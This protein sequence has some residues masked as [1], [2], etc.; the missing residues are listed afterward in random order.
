MSKS[1]PH[2]TG[3]PR[4]F[5]RRSFLKAAGASA[6]LLPFLPTLERHAE[7]A[8]GASKRMIVITH[9]NGNILT[10]WRPTGGEEDF[11]LPSILEPLEP[12][13]ENLLVL[14]GL[15]NVAYEQNVQGDYH[16]GMG[17]LWSGL[18]IA[19]G[20]VAPGI[21][22]DQ[23][24]ANAIGGDSLLP[25]IHAG[26][27]LTGSAVRKRAHY[28]GLN[29]IVQPDQTP[30]DLFNRVFAESALDPADF[31][32]L[33]DQRLGVLDAVN[34]D[35][36]GLK[37]KLS[38]N[39]VKRMDVH[40][41]GVHEITQRLAA[42]QLACEIPSTP[43]ELSSSSSSDYSAIIDLHIDL[44]VQALACDVTRVATLQLGREG[45]TGN[46]RWVDGWEGEGIHTMSHGNDDVSKGHMSNLFRWNAERVARLVQALADTPDVDGGTLLDNTLIVWGSA[47]SAGWNHASRNI[48]FVVIEGDNGYFRTG[49]HL[50]WG[51]WDNDA[52][53]H[54][55]HGGEPHNRLLV[56]LCHAM[57]LTDQETFGLAEFGGALDEL[58]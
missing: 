11:V 29:E 58:C 47:M 31:E 5:A 53:P 30:L 52:A 50:R 28:R 26:A 43:A 51:T 45:S 33:R 22:V 8:G 36:N 37:S 27:L 23:H 46:G 9:G 55:D 41:Q 12:F 24:V 15:D 7:A 49:R 18:P 20:L 56:S 48:P 44:I 35:L 17:S 21:T 4:A 32:R 13:R 54:D 40:L 57:G 16:N 2:G 34:A 42:D 14:D 38:G 39:D 10:D 25:S 3:R 19:D 6:A 1:A